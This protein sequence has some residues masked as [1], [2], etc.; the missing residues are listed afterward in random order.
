MSLHSHTTWFQPA[1]VIS[2]QYPALGAHMCTQRYFRD[3][4][5]HFLHAGGH[6]SGTHKFQW[7]EIL[8]IKFLVRDYFLSFI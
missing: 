1:E 6:C 4:A 7:T 8:Q 3:G 5:S 2:T